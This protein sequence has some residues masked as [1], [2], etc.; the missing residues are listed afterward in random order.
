MLGKHK[1]ALS[2]ENSE[3][4]KQ[5]ETVWDQGLQSLSVE[6]RR[7]GGVVPLLRAGPGAYAV[8]ARLVFRVSD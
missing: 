1:K 7:P 4:D 8:V 2:P 6:S 3:N 5:F